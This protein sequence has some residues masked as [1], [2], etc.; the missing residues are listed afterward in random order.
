M[1]SVSRRI[2]IAACATLPL[3]WSGLVAADEEE[4]V[5]ETVDKL[6]GNYRFSGGA[7]ERRALD[8]AIE[9]VVRSMNPLVRPFAR[10]ALKRANKIPER[11]R[12]SRADDDLTV[13]LDK[14]VYTAPINGDSVKVKGITGDML[15]LSYVVANGRIE[16]RFVG[17]SGGRTNVLAPRGEKHMR[18]AVRVYSDKLPKDL[19]YGLTYRRRPKRD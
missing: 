5:D 11:A 3:A 19:L 4:T 17:E 16:Q 18:M 9:S 14:R 7:K 13:E 2:I 12:I 6:L 10:K 8:A 1:Q 15:D